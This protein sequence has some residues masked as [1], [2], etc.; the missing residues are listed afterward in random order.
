MIST[1]PPDSDTPTGTDQDRED[2]PAKQLEALLTKL[3]PEF[4]AAY[5]AVLAGSATAEAIKYVRT[6]PHLLDAVGREIFEDCLAI[7]RE[8]R[9]VMQAGRARRHEAQLRVV[10]VRPRHG[11]ERRPGTNKRRR[12]SRRSAGAG[13]GGSGDDDGESE[14]P[15]D[16]APQARRRTAEAAA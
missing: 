3:T 14:P 11:R 9:R 4:V 5:R 6:R 8:H 7:R 16:L 2:S 12:G 1:H 15:G 13:G 10:T